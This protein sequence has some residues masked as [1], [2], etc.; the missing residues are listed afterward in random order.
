MAYTFDFLELFSGAAVITKYVANTGVSVGPPIDIGTSPEFDMRSTYLLNWVIFLIVE[1]KVWGLFLSPPCTTFSIMRRPRLRSREEPLGFCP[2]EEKTALGNALAC[3]AQ[4]I[5][6]VAA[7]NDAV[8]IAETPFSAYMKHLPAWKANNRH[9]NLFHEIRCD[10]CR[11]GSVHRTSFRLLGLRLDMEPLALS[12]QCNKKHVKVEGSLTKASATYVDGL[13]DEISKVLVEGVQAQK[14]SF[15]ERNAPDHKGLESQVINDVMASSTWNVDAVWSFR[16]RCHINILEESA[17]YRL[18]RIVSQEGRPMRITLLVDSNVVRCATSKGRT[19]SRGLG[20]ILRKVCCFCIACGLMLSVGFIPTRLNVADDPTRDRPPRDPVEGMHFEDWSLDD[21]WKLASKPKLRRWASNWCRLT[22]LLVGPSLLNLSDRSLFR[23]TNLDDIFL[24]H[25]TTAKIFDSTLGY[26]GE[27]PL[28]LP[29]P[30]L[31]LSI[32][33]SILSSAPP[34]RLISDKTGCKK[35][36]RSRCSPSLWS[37]VWVLGFPWEGP[38][39]LCCFHS[40]GVAEAM[41]VIARTP[42]ELRKAQQRAVRPELVMGRPVTEATTE[43]RVRHWQAFCEWATNLGIDLDTLLAT[44]HQSVEDINCLLTRYGR[45]L[46]RAGRTYNQY[47]ETI[48][49]LGSRVPSLRRVLQQAWDYGYAWVRSEPSVHHIALPVPILLAM[50]ST[51]LVWGWVR[52]ASSLALGFGG[53]LRP[54]EITGAFRRDLLV[55][56]DVGNAIAHCLLSI[57]EPKSRF[58]FARH[59]TA[60]VDSFDM[61]R[62]IVLGFEK[63]PDSQRLWPYSPQTL[64]TRYKS[65]LRALALPTEGSSEM[66]ALDLG[67]LR[68]GGATFIISSTDDSELC[69]RRG[70]WASMKM[71]DIYVQETMALQYMRHI[72]AESRTRVLQMAHAFPAILSRAEQLASVA[73]PPSTWY[74]FFAQWKTAWLKTTGEEQTGKLL[75]HCYQLTWASRLKS[76]NGSYWLTSPLFSRQ[77]LWMNKLSGRKKELQPAELIYIYIYIYTLIYTHIQTY[78]HTYMHAC[79]HACIHICAGVTWWFIVVD[80]GVLFDASW[81]W[82]MKVNASCALLCDRPLSAEELIWWMSPFNVASVDRVSLVRTKMHSRAWL[83]TNIR[84]SG[85]GISAWSSNVFGTRSFSCSLSLSMVRTSSRSPAFAAH[86][87]IGW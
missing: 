55:P 53:L 39:L 84:L 74:F 49:S 56:S 40:L 54:G 41:P 81:L 85:S 28:N 46:Y 21:L 83:T 6:R 18:C 17:V 72:S 33:F 59:R 4:Q 45:E 43:A 13:A 1:R 38:A 10:S 42:G 47:A 7:V 27:G 29:S 60:K 23:S 19:S 31:A 77:Q 75:F 79:M 52:E 73:I 24:H 80:F 5:L 20:P 37:V 61:V 8:G 71:M 58:T 25:H 2:G 48:N 78:I 70:R 57:R 16:G 87:W 14:S 62:T 30:A 11:F 65:L 69:R 66:R 86:R 76:S 64:R 67:S 36:S 32:L 15:A 68:A 35:S 82:R 44:P 34:C 9:T 51:A 26:P 3:R 12:C 63:I 22:L 50:L